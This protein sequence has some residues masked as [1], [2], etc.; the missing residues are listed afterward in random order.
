MTILLRKA[1]W[2]WQLQ[3]LLSFVAH[4]T[5]YP[6]GVSIGQTYLTSAYYTDANELIAIARVVANPKWQSF[7]S[8]TWAAGPRG[9]SS[10]SPFFHTCETDAY[11][12]TDRSLSDEDVA[13]LFRE[14]LRQAKNATE[15]ALNE[16][17]TINSIAVPFHLQHYLTVL[18]EAAIDEGF[19]TQYQQVTHSLNADRLAYN[20]DSCV[21][22]EIP[23]ERC[24]IDGTNLVLVFN[25][26]VDH[27]T[28]AMLDV[29]LWTISSHNVKH[30]VQFRETNGSILESARTQEL[31][32]ELKLY[33][34]TFAEEIGKKWKLSEPLQ[35]LRA[36]VL[37]GEASN[38]SME[39]MH[40][41]LAAALPEYEDKFRMS[42]DPHF[43]GAFG[44]A[45]RAR[46]IIQIP[47]FLTPPDPGFR[48][49]VDDYHD[50]L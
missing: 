44:A 9:Q 17:I 45:Q 49:F 41:A 23:P 35:Y 47:K 46:Q 2:Q 43:V 18:S 32:N 8:E 25:L 30:Y 28:V 27:L 6:V 5:S 24:D 31:S 21:G 16:T 13:L 22:F 1:S 14:T 7:F 42:L 37:S 15:T 50:E 20:L 4:A 34:E 38:S 10:V 3:L 29:Q 11:H 39:E 48:I 33:L 40:L 36:V 19:T 26:E 12:T